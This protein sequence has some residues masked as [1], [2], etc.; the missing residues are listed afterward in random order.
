MSV[1]T[2]LVVS[3]SALIST[4]FTQVRLLL[5]SLCGLCLL[6]CTASP[7]HKRIKPVTGYWHT[8]KK[9]ESWTTLHSQHQLNVEDV[10]AINGIESNAELT[11]GQKVFLFG[12]RGLA[13]ASPKKVRT[14]SKAKPARKPAKSRQLPPQKKK[15]AY[16][17]RGARLTSKFGKRGN[18]PHKGIDLAAK[19]GTPIYATADGANLQWESSAR[20]W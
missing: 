13:K 11:A 14:S 9:G 5:F 15:W 18:R 17:I 19:M 8:V 20:V 12:V 7:N 6:S 16:P 10:R 1:R 3:D 2:G 4:S